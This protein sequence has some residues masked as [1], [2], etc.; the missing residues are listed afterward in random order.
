MTPLPMNRFL[1]HIIGRTG[2]SEGNLL[3]RLP[4]GLQ[5]IRSRE[6][7]WEPT[8]C[9]VRHCLATATQC[10]LD[11]KGAQTLFCVVNCILDN[12]NTWNKVILGLTRNQWICPL[13]TQ[14]LFFMKGCRLQL[15]LRD[16]PRLRE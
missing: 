10:V 12:V 7:F 3:S 1:G 9:V 15:P 5:L 16:D 2:R 11:R 4:A 6:R 8:T 13:G 14:E